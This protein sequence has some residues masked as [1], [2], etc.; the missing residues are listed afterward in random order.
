MALVTVP[1]GLWIPEPAGGAEYPAFDNHLIDADGEK[2]AVIF[3]APKTGTL[4]R[5]EFRLGAV[6]QAPASGLKCSFQNIALATGHP[7][8]VVDENATVTAGLTANTWVNPGSF[9]AG[10]AVT[11]GDLVAAVIEFATF[12]AG[13]SLQISIFTAS[14]FTAPTSVAYP[15]H[16]TAGAWAKQTDRGA[17][18]AV[19]YTDGT[20]GLIP[21]ILPVSALGNTAFSSAST[22]D[23]RGMR[24]TVPVA[25]R[26]QGVLYRLEATAGSTYDVV[27]YEGSTV[28]ETVTVDTDTLTTNR[29]R[30]ALFDSLLAANTVYRVV[31]KPTATTQA[32]FDF[33]VNAAAIMD[34]FGGGQN[35]HHTQRTDAGAWTDTPTKRTWMSLWLSQVHDGTPTQDQT[36]KLY[37][38]DV[39]PGEGDTAGTFTEAAGFGYAA[40][41]LTGPGWTIVNGDPTT[42]SYAAQ[43]F[44]FTGALGNV[45]GYFIV[46]VTS[47]IL[48]WAE[49]FPDGPYNVVSNGTT[50][51]VTPT[52]GAD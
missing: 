24:F 42:A 3:R 28:L 32:D 20:Y 34:A 2:V 13:D 48:L 51:T 17:V 4:D 5:F 29:Q 12:G 40:K 43:V 52:L 47:G 44:T 16:K 30:L 1:G 35:F 7:D 25:C 36:L 50:I 19:R 46:Q 37:V 21:S 38:N 14:S 15:D 11:R 26:L 6:T 22:P 33:S 31:I 41:T 8:E 18:L 27:L 10:R 9:S 23:E 39:F 45:F 49:R